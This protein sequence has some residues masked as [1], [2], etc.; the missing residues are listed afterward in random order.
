MTEEPK[1]ILVYKYGLLPP[2]KNG[3]KVYEQI[4]L[5]R[6]YYNKLVGLERIRREKWSRL[7][8]GE[9]VEALLL[10]KS[11]VTDELEAVRSE[12]KE[13]KKRGLTTL[14]ELKTKADG[15]RK[16]R[17]SLNTKLKEARSKAKLLPEISAAV[18]KLGNDHV[19]QKKAA[20]TELRS[21]GLYCGAYALVDQDVARWR[22]S[23]GRP[24]FR[25]RT[26]EG[27]IGAQI[28]CGCSVESLASN[29]QIQF[30]PI[31]EENFLTRSGR[32]NK[33]RT[34]LRIRIGSDEKRQPVW[35]EFPM[36]M[37]RKLPEGAIVKWVVV[38]RR[39]IGS[40][41]KW[42]VCFTLD[43]T[44]TPKSVARCKTNR[45]LSLDVGW[46][47]TENGLRIAM[48]YDGEKTFEY[49][50]LKNKSGYDPLSRIAHAASIQS[51]RDKNFDEIKSLII[52]W[53]VDKV[54]PDALNERSQHIHSWR[55]QRRLSALF[56]VWKGCR[57][58]GDETIFELVKDWDRQDRH[59]WDWSAN[60]TKRALGARREMYRLWALDI[61]KR[62]DVV[63]I[64][65][66]DMK[67]F[68]RTALP[69]Q[70]KRGSV[71]S[72]RNR[73]FVA[74]SEFREE[75]TRQAEKWGVEIVEVNPAYTSKKCAGCG[76]IVKPEDP[77]AVMW[78]CQGCGV[79]FDRDENA[80]K[81]IWRRGVESHGLVI[82]R[83]VLAENFGGV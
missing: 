7:V 56:H 19:T 67:V 60:E 66:M 25:R 4:E 57:V 71:Q 20:R 5:A 18:E 26:G 80:A 29:S 11:R 3:D 37:H 8:G 79:V 43:I 52:A 48:G 38:T 12:I 17:S 16:H 35:S 74:I 51:I 61:V 65:K 81:N 42:D 47:V 53:K 39:R 21:Q 34:T 69:E 22:S 46:R 40:K 32:R 70:E 64:E 76:V 62:F 36:T 82:S 31:P 77:V 6:L 72:R 14:V 15:L 28:A 49:V 83:G 23:K 68:A 33:C 58:D 55:S 54:L 24:Q 2:T 30:D 27:R 13:N 75:L 63:I 10:E 50:L 9:E 78:T 73:H 45:A 44:D 1:R 41:W 59:L